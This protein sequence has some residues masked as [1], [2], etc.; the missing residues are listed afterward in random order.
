MR[1]SCFARSFALALGA[2]IAAATAPGHAE[3]VGFRRLTQADPSPRQLEA[4]VWYPTAA[5]QPETLLG[6]NAVFVGVPVIVD[7]VPAPGR[8]RLV[9]LSHGYGGNIG[10]QAWLAVALARRG[11]VVAAVNH[12]GTTSRDRTP[13]IGAR[14]W[15]RSHDLSRLIDQVTGDPALGVIADKVGVVG[16]SLGGWT[17]I[18]IA[19]ARFDPARIAADC[20]VNAGLGA[21]VAYR[22]LGAGET[23]E[24]RA[25][26]ASDLRDPRFG[27]AV[28]IDLG[29]ARGF[30]PESLAAVKVPVLVISA[31]EGDD[32]IPAKLESGYLVDHLPAEMVT[33][34]A[35]DGAAHFT[36]LPVCKPGAAELLEADTPGDGII[37][38]DG[39]PSAGREALH[40]KAAGEVAR[41]LD[42]A[43][44]PP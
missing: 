3:G 21:C 33:S 30:T 27:A 32:R 11:Y 35:L 17:A 10:N 24:A 25:K 42:A 7:A 6:D 19:G 2:V 44:G 1:V 15:E 26:L 41:F 5:S 34:V 8:H 9:V 43:L 38:A 14:L 28:A 4:A 31:G 22:E 20:A 29:L 37:C 18:A 12:P 39:T 36:F 23:P 13:E 40:A 16:H